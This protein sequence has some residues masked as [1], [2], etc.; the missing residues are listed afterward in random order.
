MTFKGH[1]GDIYMYLPSS[2]G[3]CAAVWCCM[4]VVLT[5]RWGDL[6]VGVEHGMTP[7]LVSITALTGLV[8]HP[9][10]LQGHVAV[11]LCH[12]PQRHLKLFTEAHCAP[13]PP[14]ASEPVAHLAKRTVAKAVNWGLQTTCEACEDF[15]LSGMRW[16]T[17]HYLPFY[18]ISF[19]LN[20]I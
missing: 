4:I 18:L 19:N 7:P 1:Q 3:A 13:S 11:S 9:A 5:I 12:E 20:F 2:D 16:T 15:R 10:W 14:P 6:C 17:G 8:V